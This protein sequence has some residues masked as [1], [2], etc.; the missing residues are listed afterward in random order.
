MESR[1][2][3]NFVQGTDWKRF[4]SHVEMAGSRWKDGVASRIWRQQRERWGEVMVVFPG[5]EVWL[6]IKVV[7]G[8]EGELGRSSRS[9]QAIGSVYNQHILIG[10]VHGGR[11]VTVLLGRVGLGVCGD[12]GTEATWLLRWP[13]K[14]LIPMWSRKWENI[15]V[16][17]T[18]MAISLFYQFLSSSLGQHFLINTK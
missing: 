5:R 8:G 11:K 15:L 13:R 18:V 4:P 17:H 16:E 7:E 2:L 1:E 3:K 14:W 12:Y 9:C 10:E 6:R